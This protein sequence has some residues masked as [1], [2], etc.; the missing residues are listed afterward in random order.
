MTQI[1][2]KARRMIPTLSVTQGN[3]NVNG[4]AIGRAALIIAM[5][6][7]IRKG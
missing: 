1:G 3:V 2:S 7:L 5:P 4:A 6:K